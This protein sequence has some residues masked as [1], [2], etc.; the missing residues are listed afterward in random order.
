MFREKLLLVIDASYMFDIA[1]NRYNVGAEDIPDVFPEGWFEGHLL[2]TIFFLH[3]QINT[4]APA[5]QSTP[6]AVAARSPGF[7]R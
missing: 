7:I 5:D 1:S 4:I 6:I 2:D 3:R